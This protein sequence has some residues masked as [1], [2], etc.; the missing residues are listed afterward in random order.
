[1]DRRLFLSAIASLPLVGATTAIAQAAPVLQVTAQPG[2]RAV[3]RPGQGEGFL[4]DVTGFNIG[5]PPTAR[6]NIGMPP[7][8]RLG[9][10]EIQDFR[11]RTITVQIGTNL[12]N[13][14][15]QDLMAARFQTGDRRG[16]LAIEMSGRNRANG[17]LMIV[18]SAAAA[19]GADALGRGGEGRIT[20]GETT[21]G[22]LLEVSG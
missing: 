20:I 14:E 22:F 18:A 17:F 7:A 9:N 2:A 10:F 13:F 16:S 5:M 15:I 12:G 4:L 3:V 8:T 11:S 21:T 19:F 6:F 1:M